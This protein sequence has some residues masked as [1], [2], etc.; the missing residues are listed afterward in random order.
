MK[1]K[2]F[3]ISALIVVILAG[4]GYFFFMNGKTPDVNYRIEKV[5]RGDIQLVVTATGTLSAVRTVVV[6]SQ[7]SG[8]LSK[9]NVDFN[10]KVRAGQIIAQID[11][12]FLEASV[13]DAEANQQRT[14]AQLNKAQRAYE[15]T[16][17]LMDKSLAS[18]A[19]YD[20]ALT[21]F[22]SASAADKQAIAQLE[23]A[24]IN[25]Q[26][27][28]IRAP[29]NGVII[30]RAVDVG[31][32]V[33]ASFSAPTL[34]TIANDLTKMQVQANVDESD[35]GKVHVEQDVNFT[36]DAYPEQTFHGKV[37]QVRLNSVTQQNVVNYTVIIDVPNDDMKLMPGMT[38]TVTILVTKKE[39]VLKVPTV[40]LR[41]QPSQDQ[42]EV[43]KDTSEGGGNGEDSARAE[44]RKQWQQR[45]QEGG[46]SGGGGMDMAAIQKR[47]ASRGM[48][49]LWILNEKKKLEQVMVRT[50]LSDGTFTEIV[51][52]KIEE[53]K[54]IVVGVVTVRPNATTASP[55]GSQQQGGGGRPR[56]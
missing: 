28:T 55:F 47:M 7:V 51:R 41:F 25:L 43:R 23:R 22:E 19:D 26:Y 32:T 27:A 37:R 24:K 30:S 53:G 50:G 13:H 46:N 15:R 8:T 6:G 14:K 39:A 5:T 9:I 36:V 21:D 16:K 11:P 56:F 38:A 17:A 52:G 2:V 40:A 54:E 12:T 3:L 20:A 18:P 42:I 1:R 49:R 10:S 34:F 35:I 31:Q 45:M 4:L 33:A 44:R 48:G 29:D